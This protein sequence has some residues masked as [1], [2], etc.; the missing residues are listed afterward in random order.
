MK[1]ITEAYLVLSDFKQRIDYDNNL[2]RQGRYF[3]QARKEEKKEVSEDGP[4]TP[5]DF[6]YQSYTKVRQERESEFDESILSYLQKYK[7][8]L[9]YAKKYFQNELSDEDLLDI[10]LDFMKQLLKNCKVIAFYN[11]VDSYEKEEI[12]DK[13]KHL[14]IHK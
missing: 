7:K 4:S 10:D 5:S 2:K 8:H 1:Q 9:Y 14:R 6:Q 13:P 12:I 3:D 11:T